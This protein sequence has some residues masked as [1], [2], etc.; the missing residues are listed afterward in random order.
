[1]PSL[2]QRCNTCRTI[3]PLDASNFKEKREEGFSKTCLECLQKKQQNFANKKKNEENKENPDPAAENSSKD[4]SD[5]ADFLTM[6]AVNLD[7]FL[8]TLSACEA[9]TSISARVNVST[10]IGSGLRETADNVAK[11]IWNCLRYR[12]K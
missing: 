8:S 9:I 3:K 5:A 11:A 10:I 6:S 2:S 1:M 4:V 12:F 7:V